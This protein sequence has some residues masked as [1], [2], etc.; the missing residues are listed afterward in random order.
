MNV[1]ADELATLYE[2]ISP[3]EFYRQIFPDGELDEW[4]EHPEQREE[5]RY[6]GIIVEI[7]NEKNE[8][9]KPRIK[10]YT[11]TDDLDEID[12]VIWGNNFCVLAP[13]SYVGKSRKSE[14]A[15]VMYALVVELDNLL[16]GK[17]GAQKGLYSL[18]EQWS[19][20]VHWIPKPTYTVASGNGLHL[21]YL[22]ERGIPLFPNVVK[23][24]QAY[25]REL[26]KKI[27][28]RHTTT[29]YRE[30]KIQFESIF[31][32]FR[33][34]GTITKNG[35]RVYA[36]RTG[37][38]VSIEYMNSFIL[39]ET[40]KKHPETQ[41]TMI[42]KSKL[43]LSEARKKYP[44][45]YER[46]IE[47][48]EPKGHWICKRA[49]YD[50]WKRKIEEEA[51]VG[52]RYYCMMMLSIYAVKCD[53]SREELE[54]D[55]LELAEVFEGKTT[56]EDNH[57]TNKDVLDALQSFEDKGLITYP[58]NS[59]ANRSGIAIE[60]NKRNGRKQA[61][62]LQL[63]RGIRQIKCSM[64]ET[65]SGGGRP[66]KREIVKEW[67]AAHPEGR[68]IDCERETGLSRHTVLK[69]WDSAERD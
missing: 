55:C 62:H 8:N 4:R 3:M 22:F 48:K 63:A 35:D 27:W 57:F 1:L 20:K 18:I 13:I 52:H 34:V 56:S 29:D 44:D 58:V 32:A 11:V 16:V 9:G 50:W 26:T 5:H 40:K 15:R 17:D 66:D 61:Q 2:D 37:E 59:I 64:G 30:E 43:T 53:I 45:W 6:T 60:K 14:N 10:R 24:L 68:K 28:N 21:Y 51:V 42:Y 25:K 65:V 67:R 12:G 38:R 49:L 7:T 33:M 23:E 69:W 46:R 47:R 39:E 19:E 31:Q 54:A 36:F 41:I